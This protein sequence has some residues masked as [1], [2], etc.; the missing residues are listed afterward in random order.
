MCSEPD[1]FWRTWKRR[2][3]V[4]RKAYKCYECERPIPKGER[5]VYLFAVTSD[6]YVDTFST[7]VACEDLRGFIEDVVCGGHG[8]VLMG[9]LAEEIDEAGQYLDQNHDAWEAAGLPVPNPL[10]EVFDFIRASYPVQDGG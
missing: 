1:E 7:H 4:A 3:P 8:G 5:Y 10:R 2:R 9:R 6:G